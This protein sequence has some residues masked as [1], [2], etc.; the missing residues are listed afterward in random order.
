MQLASPTVLTGGRD[1]GIERKAGYFKN[2]TVQL[3]YLPKKVVGIVF[4]PNYC[5]QLLMLIKFTGCSL[6]ALAR[7]RQNHIS[8]NGE[9]KPMC[10]RYP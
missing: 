5:N 4:L 10:I 9:N 7:T 6:A 1:S 2:Q 3:T 8:M